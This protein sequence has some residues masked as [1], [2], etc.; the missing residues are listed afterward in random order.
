[1]T[2]RFFSAII[3][4]QS[5]ACTLLG[6][7]LFPLSNRFDVTAGLLF[8]IPNQI[9]HNRRKRCLATSYVQRIRSIACKAHSDANDNDIVNEK[10]KD[11]DLFDYFDP[12]LS[13]HLYPGGIPSPKSQVTTTSSTVSITTI[14]EEEERYFAESTNQKIG[15]LLIDHGSKRESSNMHLESLARAYERSS[16][17][18][19][20]YI[21]R[22]AHMEIASPSIEDGLRGLI[23]E[24]ACKLYAMVSKAIMLATLY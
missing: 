20:H 4:M 13:P 23:A 18:P 11:Y 16:R 8:A 10:P 22:A 7:L 6:G 14:I 21:V 12:R 5:I 24:G 15:I 2:S 17:C 1:M 9:S 19:P 3:F